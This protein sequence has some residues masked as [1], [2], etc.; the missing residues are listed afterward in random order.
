MNN[1][2]ELLFIILF[3]WEVQDKIITEKL[4]IKQTNQPIWVIE[5]KRQSHYVQESKSMTEVTL[6]LLHTE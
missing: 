1:V 6:K 3:I 5:T 4:K 2:E